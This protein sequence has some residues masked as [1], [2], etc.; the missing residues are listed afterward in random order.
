M[1]L[2]DLV[3]LPVRALHGCRAVPESWGEVNRHDYTAT[4]Q[5]RRKMIVLNALDLFDYSSGSTFRI[6]GHLR[7]LSARRSSRYHGDVSVVVRSRRGCG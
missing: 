1:T 2:P 3:V 6:I 5:N 4:A 7:E